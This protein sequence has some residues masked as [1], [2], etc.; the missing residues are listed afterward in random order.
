MNWLCSGKITKSTG[1][2]STIN[3]CANACLGLAKAWWLL[4]MQYSKR[5]KQRTHKLIRTKNV[6]ALIQSAMNRLLERRKNFAGAAS[7]VQARICR[8]SDASKGL[9]VHSIIPHSPGRHDVCR[10]HTWLVRNLIQHWYPTHSRF[11]V[12]PS[13]QP[14]KP[15]PKPA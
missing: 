4:L 7:Q 8:P 15:K 5:L 6:Q 3:S 13:R 9:K 11:L 1:C 14:W 2:I 10:T 12:H